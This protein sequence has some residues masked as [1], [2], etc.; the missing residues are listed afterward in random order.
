MICRWE[1]GRGEEKTFA[2]PA[3]LNGGL[4]TLIAL[5]L[6]AFST[7]HVFVTFFRSEW[8][9]QT[10]PSPLDHPFLLKHKPNNDNWCIPCQGCSFWQWCL[11]CSMASV[12]SLFYSPTLDPLRRRLVALAL[13]VVVAALLVCLLPLHRPRQPP[14]PQPLRRQYQRPCLCLQIH[15]QL[16][17]LK[18]IPHRRLPPLP[19][20]LHRQYQRPFLC[21]QIHCQLVQN[22]DT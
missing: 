2:G 12:C 21:C 20:P 19:R 17:L 5:V 3:V 6:L 22:Y 8:A 15:C 4:T 7:S 11:A 10:F 14:L 9:M 13:P 18:N 1:T 16:R